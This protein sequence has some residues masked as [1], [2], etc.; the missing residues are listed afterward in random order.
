MTDFVKYLK[1]FSSG[2]KLAEK[3]K[4]TIKKQ[5]EE[6]LRKRDFECLLDLCEKDR[7][8][9]HEV[10]FRLYDLDEKLRWTAIQTVAKFMH[11]WWQSGKEDKV[12][13]YI[14]TLFWSMTDESGGIG[15]SAPQTVAEI[16]LYI[17][18]IIDPYGSMM[19][20]YSLDEPPLVKGGLWG[21]GRLG[22]KIADSV[23]FFKDKI[24]ATFSIDDFETLGLASWAMGEACFIPAEPFLE[25]LKS[26]AEYVKIYIGNDFFEQ[27][28]GQ[29]ARDALAKIKITH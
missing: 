28:L 26:S 11:R 19:M 17:P 9:W 14:R 15:W 1:Y 18:E 25:H 23:V 6:L 21:I 24:L 5:V 2:N 22:R 10:R 20:A 13:Q 8:Y 7:H 3:M 27:P 12:R 29:W 16:I 4:E